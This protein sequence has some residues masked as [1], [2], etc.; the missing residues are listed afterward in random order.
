MLKRLAKSAR[1]ALNRMGVDIRRSA[2]RERIYRDMEPEFFKIYDVC[3]PFTMTSIER[4]YGLYKALQYVVENK[5][6]GDIVEC[7]VWR[8]GSCMLIASTLKQ[9]G[10]T[11]RAIYLYDTFEG[12]PAPTA[13]DI[14]HDGQ[15]LETKWKK[16][17]AGTHNEWCYASLEDV[18][19]NLSTIDYPQDKIRYAVGRVEETIPG[20]MPASISLLRLDTDWYES[21]KH[22]MTH[23]YPKLASRGILLIDD[24]GHWKGSRDAVDES[25]AAMGIKP[26]LGRIDYTGR[27]FVK[28]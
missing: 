25:F 2:P 17:D 6:P 23:L 16:E 14:S 7:G 24:Y 19:K 28:P 5:I 12:M 1:T 13:A 3:A 21:T 18:K 26:Y 8:G 20:Q 22:E 10:D 27:V 4:M 11:S 15:R 9:F